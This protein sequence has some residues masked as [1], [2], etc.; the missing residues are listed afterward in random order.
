MFSQR[1]RAE[2]SNAGRELESS[3]NE[4]N[5]RL[6]RMQAEA[7]GAQVPLRVVSGTPPSSCSPKAG[8]AG[9]ASER[10]AGASKRLASSC[11]SGAM[12]GMGMARSMCIE[13]ASFYAYRLSR[14]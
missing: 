12:S 8:T 1:V 4:V 11:S 9:P 10:S 6:A 3:V 5:A 13:N 2:L 14:V 7:R